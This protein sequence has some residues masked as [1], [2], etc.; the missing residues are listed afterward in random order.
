MGVLGSS[1][2]F[3]CRCCSRCKCR[4]SRRGGELDWVIFQLETFHGGMKDC[5]TK[6]RQNIWKNTFQF[7]P[8]RDVHE[9]RYTCVTCNIPNSFGF[10]LFIFLSTLRFSSYCAVLDW[11]YYSKW[12]MLLG[13]MDPKS[14]YPPHVVTKNT[15]NLLMQF[16]KYTDTIRFLHPFHGA[17]GG[18]CGGDG[19]ASISDSSNS[20]PGIKISWMKSFES[21]PQ[22]RE[23]YN[24]TPQTH[25]FRLNLV[26]KILYPVLKHNDKR[27]IGSVRK[28]LRQD[29]QNTC[30]R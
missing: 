24:T 19:H 4:L 3:S 17:I 22:G 7:N 2:C 16:P 5:D 28:S 10:W 8:T 23:Q 15:V 30:A 12:D 26:S 20:N 9:S 11:K 18:W 14:L 6:C 25:H 1:E 27:T 29:P 21:C 13:C